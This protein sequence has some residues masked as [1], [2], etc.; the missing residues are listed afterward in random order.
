MDCRVEELKNWGNYPKLEALVCHPRSVEEVRE[1][2]LHQERLIARGNGRCYGDAALGPCVL[3]TLRLNRILSFDAQ[4]GV[5]WA[6]SGALLAD[7]LDVIVPQGWFF[8][9]TPGTRFITV[10]GAIACD[11][12]GKNHPHKGCF[13]RWLL[14]FEL[15]RADGSIVR[16]SPQENAALFW[17]TCGGMGWTGV[18]LSARFRLMRISSVFLR[19][20][21]LR[22]SCLEEL[23][24]AFEAHTDWPYA[25]AWVDGLARG[26]R[27]GRGI[28]LLAE[29]WP[30]E[31]SALSFPRHFALNIP[32][33][34]PSFLLNRCVL[35]LYNECYFTC[36][37]PGEQRVDLEQC[38]YPLD[39]VRH[40]NR[41]YGRRG[42]VQY[43][44]CLPGEQAFLGFRKV[45][46]LIHQSG[47]VP[48][49]CVVKRHG[50]RPPEAVNSFPESGYSL[51]VDFAR[52]PGLLRL[53]R[54]LDEWVWKLGGKVYLA[55]DACSAPH[56]GRISPKR[57]GA[58][59]FWSLLR[60]RIEREP[61]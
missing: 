30:E 12:H 27:L 25:V 32:V 55:K 13:S 38:F 51:A 6:Q 8:H 5:V 15:L 46:E 23:L 18:I 14:D 29:H 47:E 26:R 58:E 61:N 1:V 16:C 59:K 44:F 34:A 49:L 50:E 43:Q 3:S 31:A 4:S 37:R 42:L 11:V 9:V 24:N 41:L 19:Q 22:A 10:G 54:Q 21:T 53:I 33:Y 40:W 35:R 57:V 52:T 60:E 28:L 2:V 48:F 7:L 39:R 45:F 20:R 17:Q 56:M 36:A